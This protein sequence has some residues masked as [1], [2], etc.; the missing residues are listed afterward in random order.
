MFAMS[1][2]GRIARLPT[3]RR[4]FHVRK[5]GRGRTTRTGALDLG[6][7]TSVET[8]STP[9]NKASYPMAT[10][11]YYDFPANGSRPPVK[12]TW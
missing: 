6:F 10:M 4:A 7:P 5:P 12:L 8:V 11:T 3:G 2:S 9:F 1:T